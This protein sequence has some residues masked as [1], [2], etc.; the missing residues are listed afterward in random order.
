[1]SSIED[2][3]DRP[4]DRSAERQDHLT[5]DASL[6]AQPTLENALAVSTPV[7]GG[8]LLAPVPPEELSSREA[9]RVSVELVR[10]DPEHG[11]TS[12]CY[13]ATAV[14]EG[15]LPGVSESQGKQSTGFAPFAREKPRETKPPASHS[16]GSIVRESVEEE[17][18]KSYTSAPTRSE[19]N[20]S[21]P[22]TDSAERTGAARTVL[23]LD[24]LSGETSV[25]GVLGTIPSDSDDGHQ[26]R[27]LKVEDALAYLEQVKAQFEDRPRIYAKFLDIMKEFK[28]QT[29]DTPGVIEH[30]TRL[31][32]GYPNLVLGFNTFLPA[33]YKI[34]LTDC[35]EPVPVHSETPGPT[36]D[37]QDA[38][39][40]ASEE[41]GHILGS[42]LNTSAAVSVAT[43]QDGIRPVGPQ[44][45]STNGQEQ[46]DFEGARA[47]YGPL[48]TRQAFMHP[49]QME[50][51]PHPGSFRNVHQGPA[52]PNLSAFSHEE[53][54][55]AIHYV[56]RVKQR[57]Q[58]QPAVYQKFL[59]ILQTYQREGEDTSNVLDEVAKIFQGYP[60]LLEEFKSFLPEPAVHDAE[61]RTQVATPTIRGTNGEHVPM[62]MPSKR[63]KRTQQREVL[64]G[65]IDGAMVA[66]TPAAMP[67][68]EQAI[69][70]AP[71]AASTAATALSGLSPISYAAKGELLFFEKLRERMEAHQFHEFIKCLSLYNQEIIGRTELMSLADELFGHRHLLSEAF[72]TFLDSCAPLR[73]SKHPA[74]LENVVSGI[75]T[76]LSILE[77]RAPFSATAPAVDGL[78]RYK[79]L[80]EAAAESK[81]RC[82]TSY[83]R[84]PSEFQSMPCSGRGELE[85][86]ILNDIWVSVPTGSEEGSFKHMR[87][88]QFEDNLFRCEDDRYELDMVIET[89]AATIHKLEPLAMVIANMSDEEKAKHMLAEHALGAVHYRAIE[90]V[91]GAHGPEMVMHVKMHPS[92]AVPIVLNRLKQKDEEWRRARVEMNKIWRE[93][94]E[95]NYFKSLD[96]RSFYF[97]Q[98]DKRTISV[99]GLLQDVHDI[100]DVK[101]LMEAITVS[102]FAA[103]IM[104]GSCRSVAFGCG[105]GH[106]T[107]SRE[108]E[109]SWRARQINLAG[110]HGTSTA[111]STD[112]TSFQTSVFLSPNSLGRDPFA[113]VSAL[114]PPCLRFRLV[115]PETHQDLFDLISFLVH[116]EY[117]VPEC[118]RLLQAFERF[119]G[120]FFRI[121]LK[122]PKI[123]TNGLWN[124][125]AMNSPMEYIQS[126]T[127][128]GIAAPERGNHRTDTISKNGFTE[129]L[130]SESG[131][132][133][134]TENAREEFDLQKQLA[135]VETVCFSV[136]NGVSEVKSHGIAVAKSES[137]TDTP[138]GTVDLSKTTYKTDSVI[139]GDEALYIFLRLY[140][141]AYQRLAA[142]RLMAQTQ[143]SRLGMM[144]TEGQAMENADLRIKSISD[145]LYN[146]DGDTQEGTAT[147]SAEQTYREYTEVL[148]RYLTNSVDVQEYEDYC[149]RVLGPDSYVLFTLD[150]VLFKLVKQ[151]YNATRSKFVALYLAETQDIIR[152]KSVSDDFRDF[153]DQARSIA[154]A[155]YCLKA[156]QALRDERGGHLYRFEAVTN[157]NVTRDGSCKPRV[158]GS[159]AGE[160]LHDQLKITLLTSDEG[161]PRRRDTST[162]T[163]AAASY[164]GF[165]A[166]Q[167]PY[168]YRAQPFSNAPEMRKLY[169]FEKITVE[170]PIRRAFE[171]LYRKQRP[172][173]KIHA[174]EKDLL[175]NWKRDL[176]NQ[177]HVHNGLESKMSLY[178]HRL[179]YL[180]DTFDELIR[181][182][183]AI[184]ISERANGAPN[185]RHMTLQSMTRRRRYKRWVHYL[186]RW[187]ADSLART[188]SMQ[189]HA[190]EFCDTELVPTAET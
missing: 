124:E 40:G 91:Y 76:A 79:S 5:P 84:I 20:N 126:V 108:F 83:K 75:E 49:M 159:Q 63:A 140:E 106:P 155:S 88:N 117:A 109:Y 23:K 69:T 116:L 38:K 139:Y 60:D 39:F 145:S 2:E 166:C 85:K 13:A 10:T 53:F 16:S 178:T 110:V 31:F 100:A 130:E 62:G 51:A 41:R 153:E 78:W 142:A 55:H 58:N 95:R 3:M 177:V 86:Q 98:N 184:A 113:A 47:F 138:A 115:F 131:K 30:V 15:N 162:A 70:T 99:R 180:G 120:R 22:D 102:V 42:H 43:A 9:M 185:T 168:H 107:L 50:S 97:R 154:E 36:D 71:R 118:E 160:P 90:R 21:R 1:M 127:E 181:R 8:S 136:L 189:R 96:H 4:R 45:I 93:I 48:E 129:D 35:L 169:Y 132:P 163:E 175:Q 77:G 134:L 19:S 105:F 171:C 176:L 182:K 170:V 149:R 114:D 112:A 37:V 59:N 44:N 28:A 26:S 190:S 57:F 164:L 111:R 65:A 52:P 18:G 89:N 24:P 125:D 174:C 104:S 157:Q 33:G 25:P 64:K 32:R 143:L 46:V 150:K 66:Q 165:F 17:E 56:N 135:L 179:V 74:D 119:I 151:A 121:H 152:K 183:R 172:T 141:I 147:L 148:R 92:V 14:D 54:D 173:E 80:S 158:K 68:P 67:L 34:E 101:S 29:I 161:I 11:E 12:T 187:E 103:N 87:R 7:E 186:A 133:L 144:G 81:E 123:D 156:L 188:H 137:V 167:V 128:G 61:N 82:D 72:R 73:K 122:R 6:S 146:P 27:T 94:C